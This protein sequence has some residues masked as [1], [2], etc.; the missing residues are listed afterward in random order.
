[1]WRLTHTKKL[2]SISIDLF[3][4]CTGWHSGSP[5]PNGRTTRR[6]TAPSSAHHAYTR[7][8]CF[9]LLGFD[10]LLDNS[11]KCWLMEVNHSPSLVADTPLDYQI[12]HDV[13]TEVCA[14]LRIDYE[15]ASGSSKAV[16]TSFITTMIEIL[17]RAPLF[18]FQFWPLY[19]NK[20]LLTTWIRISY[21]IYSCILTWLSSTHSFTWSATQ[22]YLP[23]CYSVSVCLTGFL[24]FI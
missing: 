8:C 21:S 22:I 18:Y 12:K 1:M 2:C 3:H 24:F 5:N 13:I 11:G 9:E 6:S 7:S 19:Q 17:S 10:V 14:W 23:C 20:K 4:S 15:C 16:Y